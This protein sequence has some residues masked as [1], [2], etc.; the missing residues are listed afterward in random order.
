MTA[1]E[2]ITAQLETVRA[3]IAAIEAGA[4]EYTI[5]NRRLVKADLS[6]LYERETS[7]ETKLAR[8]EGKDIFFAELGSL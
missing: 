3:A 8:L 5:D 1:I 4:Q 6:T 2:R 7:L